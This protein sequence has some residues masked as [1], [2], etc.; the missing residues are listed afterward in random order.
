MNNVVS[1]PEF[2]RPT[3]HD[4]ENFVVLGSMVVG[5]A[6]GYKLSSLFEG[7]TIVGKAAE[8]GIKAGGLLIGSGVGLVAASSGLVAKQ[9]IMEVMNNIRIKKRI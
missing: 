4:I 7:K 1:F 8:A 2:E 6:V 9:E 3:E 5:A